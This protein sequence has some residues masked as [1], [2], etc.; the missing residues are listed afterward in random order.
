TM[1]FGPPQP[2][3]PRTCSAEATNRA[4]R[5]VVKSAVSMPDTAC[6]AVAGSDAKH[7]AAVAAAHARAFELVPC[8]AGDPADATA[9]EPALSASTQ[10]HRARGATVASAAAVPSP[11]ANVGASSPRRCG[12]TSKSIQRNVVYPSAHGPSALNV[13]PRPSA[14]FRLY[15]SV[16]KVSSTVKGHA[17]TR[18]TARNAAA[19]AARAPGPA[20]PARVG[21]HRSIT[22]ARLP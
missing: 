22:A 14:T 2:R 11:F 17:S 16:M 6:T 15:R 3:R 8:A 4:V 10:A 20:R 1:P 5:S 7:A 18:P 13:G 9:A 19:I 12:A 21:S